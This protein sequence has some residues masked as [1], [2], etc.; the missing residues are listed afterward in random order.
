MIPPYLL[1]TF[2][3]EHPGMALT[4]MGALISGLAALV[5][6]Y[7]KM[8]AGRLDKLEATDAALGDRVHEVEERLAQYQEHIGAGD[9]MLTKLENSIEGLAKD[10]KLY[11]GDNLTAHTLI[12]ERLA[13]VEAKMPNGQLDE[14]L[15]IVKN[16][17]GR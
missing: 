14:I 2:V 9:N 10:L 15:R 4:F 5:G 7:W 17:D 8:I 12:V 11:H 16:L 1:M 3:S 6:G 13:K